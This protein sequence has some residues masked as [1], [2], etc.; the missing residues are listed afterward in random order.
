MEL[1][2]STV[3]IW[4]Q[5][6]FQLPNDIATDWLGHAVLLF[7]Y[8]TFSSLGPKPFSHSTNSMEHSPSWKPDSN[9]AS[10]IPCLYG[11]QGSLPHSQE[12]ATGPYPVPQN[13]FCNAFQWY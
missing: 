6:T 11:T 5:C 8:L 3:K 7:T 1:T 2:Y 13:L 10:Q 4:K 12:P 9:S